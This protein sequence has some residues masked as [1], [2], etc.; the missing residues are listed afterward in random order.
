M[1]RGLGN[2]FVE[3]NVLEDIIRLHLEFHILDCIIVVIGGR[4][5]THYSMA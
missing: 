2:A 4:F 3:N 1:N 5:T